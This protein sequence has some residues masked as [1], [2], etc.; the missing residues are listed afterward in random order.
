MCS[1]GRDEGVTERVHCTLWTL[2]NVDNSGEPLIPPQGPEDLS[3]RHEEKG[4]F[5]DMEL[6]SQLRG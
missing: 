4:G 3:A 6:D 5:S 1:F 2:D